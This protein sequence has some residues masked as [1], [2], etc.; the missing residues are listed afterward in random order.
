MT[1]IDSNIVQA[2][3]CRTACSIL[4]QPMPHV[5]SVSIGIWLD[6]GSRREPA[7]K[8]GMAHFIEHMVF[9]GTER[10]SAEQIAREMDSVGGMLDAFTSKEAACFNAKVLDEHL[11]LAFD[12]LADMML[13]P[14]FAA[15]DIAKERQV[16]LEEIRMEE[17]NPESV[18]HEMTTQNFWRG[19]PLGSPILGTRTTV[20]NFSRRSLLEVFP[21]LV[22]AESYSGDCRGCGGSRNGC[23]KWCPRYLAGWRPTAR[24]TAAVPPRLNR[25]REAEGAQQLVARAG[26]HHA[27]GAVF[28]A[29]APAALRRFAAE[30]YSRRRYVFAAVSEYSRASGA[31][32]CCLQRGESVF[33][34]RDAG[35]VCWDGA[36]EHRA[37]DALGGR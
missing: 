24:K 21:A 17:D 1:D 4:T 32:V 16:V 36:A 27:G 22:C 34:R 11:P 3:A 35:G 12:V 25:T 15:E 31:G 33:R 23:T 8:N 6:A 13:R 5:R 10:R 29:G 19:H 20:G 14:K 26:A 9:K 18:V 7:A 28:S 30:Q 2:I 37:R